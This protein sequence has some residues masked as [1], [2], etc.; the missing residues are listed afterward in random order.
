MEAGD[1]EYG[2][3]YALGCKSRGPVHMVLHDSTPNVSAGDTR[4]MHRHYTD[5]MEKPLF[6]AVPPRMGRTG[7]VRDGGQG[8]AAQIPENSGTNVSDRPP[9]VQG[10]Q[11]TIRESSM[12]ED[13]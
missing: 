4:A 7:V 8:C 1:S 6:R 2:R 9:A 3:V 10:N 11:G 13:A 12:A 5:S